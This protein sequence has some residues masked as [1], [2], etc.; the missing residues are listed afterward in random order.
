MGESQYET[1]CHNCQ[2]LFAAPQPRFAL[3]PKRKCL[4][5]FFTSVLLLK[6]KWLYWV[7]VSIILFWFPKSS[8]FYKSQITTIQSWRICK[9]WC[10]SSST[11]QKD[12]WSNFKFPLFFL[13]VSTGQMLGKDKFISTSGS[14]PNLWIK[15]AGTKKFRPPSFH[16]PAAIRCEGW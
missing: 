3:F 10:S 16:F 12:Q 14:T 8:P 11:L 15:K 5:R 4:K 7:Y 2:R 13:F 1:C 6:T 9:G